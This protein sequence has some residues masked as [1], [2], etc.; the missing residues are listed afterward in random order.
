MFSIQTKTPSIE[1][2]GQVIFSIQINNTTETEIFG[3]TVSVMIDATVNESNID[4][5]T[6]K[7][8]HSSDTRFTW[9]IT[10][11]TANACTTLNYTATLPD[12]HVRPGLRLRAVFNSSIGDEI[13]KSAHATVSNVFPSTLHNRI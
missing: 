13:A 8:V 9:T 2:G 5:T 3:I 10:R 7:I 6:G 4:A 11:L 12:D 1:R